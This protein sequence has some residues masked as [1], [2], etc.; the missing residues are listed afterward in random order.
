MKTV[1]NTMHGMQQLL[2][3]RFIDSRSQCRDMRTQGITLGQIIAPDKGLDFASRHYT[4]GIF[5]EESQYL[6]R[7]RL[8]TDRLPCT[9]DFERLE[10]QRQISDV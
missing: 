1:A 9:R 3:E 5:H 4:M 6:Q 2:I 10:I 7:N 8:E